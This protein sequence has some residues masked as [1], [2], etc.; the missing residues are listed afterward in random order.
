MHGGSVTHGRN[1]TA[2]GHVSPAHPQARDN[3]A[4]PGKG[5]TTDGRTPGATRTRNAHVTDARNAM[6]NRHRMRDPSAIRDS[7][8]M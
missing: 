6:R 3:R 8:A 1:T 5:A 7:N 2:G 4:M